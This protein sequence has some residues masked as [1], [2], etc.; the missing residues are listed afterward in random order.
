MATDYSYRLLEKS[1]RLSALK[2][3]AQAKGLVTDIGGALAHVAY[4]ALIEGAK[5]MRERG[6]FTWKSR[7]PTGNDI[8]RLL[9]E[10]R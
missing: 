9:H 5:E 1:P 8:A 6:S 3:S 4:G 7:L 2:N 10:Q